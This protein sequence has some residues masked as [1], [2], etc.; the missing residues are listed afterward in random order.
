MLSYFFPFC[1][2]GGILA[3]IYF[4]QAS[5]L[6]V[7]IWDNYDQMQVSC[8]LGNTLLAILSFQSPAF[9]SETSRNTFLL[10]M[11]MSLKICWPTTSTCLFNTSLHHSCSPP[12][13]SSLL[14][15]IMPHT[16]MA[17]FLLK[18]SSHGLCFLCLWAFVI[19]L[20]CEKH[21]KYFW[22]IKS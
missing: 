19:S 3:H 20:L 21:L 2:C 4:S 5:L 7:L 16:Q 15:P 17:C 10:L 18:T 6:A 12:S 14:P 11:A 13:P 9:H 1:M 8:L 22:I